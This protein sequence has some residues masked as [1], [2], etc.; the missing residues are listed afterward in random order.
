MPPRR[1]RANGHPL[2]HYF[3]RSLAL[4]QTPNSEKVAS[5]FAVTREET[6][7]PARNGEAVCSR[8][9]PVLD[10]GFQI[11]IGCVRFTNASQPWAKVFDGIQSAGTSAIANFRDFSPMRA[12]VALNT[13]FFHSS[14]TCENSIVRYPN[15]PLPHDPGCVVRM[16]CNQSRIS[17]CAF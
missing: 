17:V 15:F 16:P 4:R 9:S 3:L 5:G 13:G 12:E 7:R 6:G 1:G 8:V 2:F 10:Y 11:A 14:F